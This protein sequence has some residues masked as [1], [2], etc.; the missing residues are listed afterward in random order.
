VGIDDPLGAYLGSFPPLKAL[1]IRQA[2]PGHGP[3]LTNIQQRIEEIEAHHVARLDLI[4]TAVDHPK[5]VYQISNILFNHAKLSSHETRFAVTET[6]A[7]LE[8]WRFRGKLERTG[9]SPW[10]YQPAY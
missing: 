6:L 2:L 1:P 4:L 9:H 8:Y 5:T 3:I 7:H 10:V